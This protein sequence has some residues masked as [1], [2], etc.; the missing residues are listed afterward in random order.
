[1]EAPITWQHPRYQVHFVQFSTEEDDGK[2]EEQQTYL[3]RFVLSGE[4]E[5]QN[6][7]EA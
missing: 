7:W 5:D 3:L 2:G 1:M 4:E 6:G